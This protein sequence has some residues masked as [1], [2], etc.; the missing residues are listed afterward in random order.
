MCNHDVFTFAHAGEKGVSLEEFVEIMAPTF[1][2]IQEDPM[3]KSIREVLVHTWTQS[4][5][6]AYEYI[7]SYTSVL[8]DIYTY[9]LVI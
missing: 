8:I 9:T 1:Q 3:E 6:Y 4:L 5:T 7:Y 2:N